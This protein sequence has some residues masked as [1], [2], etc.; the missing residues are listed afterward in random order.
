MGMKDELSVIGYQDRFQSGIIT[1]AR[2]GRML[3][4]EVDLTIARYPKVNFF[5]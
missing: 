1:E 5:L 2:L 4:P 3:N